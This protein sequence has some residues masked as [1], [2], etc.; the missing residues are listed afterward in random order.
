MIKKIFKILI[1]VVAVLIVICLM[2]GVY[3]AYLP[4]IDSYFAK[5]KQ[6]K[7][8]QIN[9][10]KEKEFI[11]MLKND[12]FGGKTPEETFD[13]FLTALKAGD[14]EKASK[15]YV[16]WK[17]EKALDNLKK[18]FKEKGNL[19]L[20]IANLTDIREKG[21]KSCSE[22]E[23]EELGGCTFEYKYITTENK[24][25]KFAESEDIV[26]FPK[27]SRRSKIIDFEF[28]KFANIWKITQ[29]W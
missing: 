2:F 4:Q 19:N 8:D 25:S 13:M 1:Y 9:A 15:Y 17:Q 21:E 12:T 10:K 28:N 11:D 14:I 22:L 7:D 18:E 6:E 26:F 29:P 23:L 24:F 3:G 27:G 5:I 16:N 20:V